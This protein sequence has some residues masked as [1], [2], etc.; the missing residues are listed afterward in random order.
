MSNTQPSSAAGMKINVA[1]K[2]KETGK[3]LFMGKRQSTWM[4]PNS[5]IQ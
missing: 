1:V 2:E 3:T 5:Q 4:A